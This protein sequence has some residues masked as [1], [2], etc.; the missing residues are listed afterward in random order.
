MAAI[1]GK[2][3]PPD[4]SGISVLQGGEDVNNSD[5]QKI[6]RLVITEPTKDDKATG[7]QGCERLRSAEG[8]YPGHVNFAES[9]NEK[10]GELIATGGDFQNCGTLTQISEAILNNHEIRI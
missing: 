4:S 8:N 2:G 1:A 10:I 6:G 9:G 5:I 3:M 7:F